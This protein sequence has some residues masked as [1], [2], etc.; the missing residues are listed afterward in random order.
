MHADLPPLCIQLLSVYLQHFCT[1][2]GMYHHT[3]AATNMTMQSSP[4]QEDCIHVCVNRF[5][6]IKHSLPC[7]KCTADCLECPVQVQNTTRLC[8]VRDLTEHDVVSRIMRK[9]NYLIGML[10]KGVLALH[11]GTP[12][13]GLR[14]KFMLT[15]TLEWNLHW[16][17]LDCMFGEDFRLKPA[18]LEDAPALQRRFRSPALISQ[19]SP[20]SMPAPRNA[21]MHLLECRP[22][23]WH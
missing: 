18:F 1:C 7:P 8:I 2:S 19:K 23:C 13:L 3:H 5:P 10:N 16:C 14:K 12:C 17:L 21:F 4:S 11:V 15:K 6:A 20:C 9:E 22:H